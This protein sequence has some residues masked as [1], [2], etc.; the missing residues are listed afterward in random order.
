MI[1]LEKAYTFY[2]NTVESS[3][4]ADEDKKMKKLKLKRAFTTILKV[5]QGQDTSPISSDSDD[6]PLESESDEEYSSS[7]GSHDGSQ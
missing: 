6:G 7:T 4:I 5:L 1:E 3:A 2:Q